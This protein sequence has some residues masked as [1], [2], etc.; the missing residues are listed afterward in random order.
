MR[1]MP[2]FN[3]FPRWMW[4][5]T[6]VRDFVEWLRT[7]NMA[8]PAGERA[9]FAGLDIY[10]MGAS[11]A[12]VT[13]YLDRH[14][15]E[16]AKVARARYNCLQPWVENPA[17]YGRVALNKGYA[18]CEEGV[19]AMLQDL[20][21]KRLELIGEPEDGDDFLDAEINARVVR[22]SERYYRAMYY[23]GAESW[24]LRDTHMFDTLARL[25]KVRPGANAV[26]WAHNS[27]IGDARHTDMIKRGELNLGQLCRQTF[28]APREVSIIGCATYGGPG[29]TVAAADEWDMPEE[30]MP[31]VLARDDSYEGLLHDTGMERFMLDLRGAEFGGD[32]SVR[33]EL[34]APRRERF[35]GVIYKPDT[36]LWSHYMMASLPKQLDAVVFFDKSQAVEAFETA[37]PDEPLSVE[38]TYPFG[39]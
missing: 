39:L 3:H 28:S 6:E 36:E 16:A 8:L 7:H 23:G 25:L 18:P 22:D 34:I 14:D 13:E 21:L 2:I 30:V 4:R 33:Q 15:P 26:V 1:N 27:H 38:D 29:S 37:Q 20:L 31:V 5:N 35:I 9:R 19:V 24:N 32:E 11:I 12:A 17:K 10:S